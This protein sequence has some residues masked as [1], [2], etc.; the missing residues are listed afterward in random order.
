LEIEYF[1]V[2]PYLFGP[3]AVKYRLRPTVEKPS[4]IPA[5][6]SDDF[7][8]EAMRQRLA[9]G[10]ARFDFMVQFQTDPYKMPVED[11]SIVWDEQLSPFRKVATVRIPPQRFDSAAQMEFCE[12]LSLNPWHSLP[13]HRPL[14]GLNRARKVVYQALTQL[15]HELNHE[16]V[17]EPTAK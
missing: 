6:P 4:E 9:A 3:R 12:N 8:R 10:E 2:V 16:P 11:P 7:L 1:S 5:S 17:Q 15:R 14:G 13:E